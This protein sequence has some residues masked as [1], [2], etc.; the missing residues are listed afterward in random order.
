MDRFGT[1]RGFGRLPLVRE[2]VGPDGAL[3]S[4]GLTVLRDTQEKRPLVFSD[5]V[6]VR[7]ESLKTGD[8]TLEGFRDRVTVERKSLDDLV[9]CCTHERSRFV[10]ELER[11]KPSRG[12]FWVSA[13]VIESGLPELLR[14]DYKSKTHPNSVLGSV[15]RWQARYRVPFVWAGSRFCAGF[16]VLSILWNFYDE[17]G[18]ICRDGAGA[19]STATLLAQ[20][21]TRG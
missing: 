14:H 3:S 12:G 19:A 11:M 8:Y 1:N 21:E 17:Y 15:N 6:K 20:S 5:C 18:K 10:R 13:V 4:A 7:I 16:A 2:G 9:G